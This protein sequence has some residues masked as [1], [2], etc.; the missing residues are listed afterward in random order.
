MADLIYYPKNFTTARRR[1]REL[2][3]Q[4]SR[5]KKIETWQVPSAQAHDL[6]ADSAYFPAQKKAK[7][8]FVFISGV[9]GLEGYTGHAIQAMFLKELLPYADQDETGFLFVHALNPWGF[10]FHS[11]NTENGVNLNRN[12][13]TRPQLYSAQ[14][15]RSLELSDR[16]IPR[17]PVDTEQCHLLQN[18]HETDAGIF[19]ADVSMDDFIK[20]VG[21]GQ[22]HSKEGLE[23]GG[24]GPEPQIRQFIRCLEEIIPQYQDIILFDI[25]TGLGHRGQLHLLTG[26]VEG[27][28]HPH[29]FNEIFNPQQDRDLY[30]FTPADAEGFYETLGATNNI[31]PEIAEPHQRVCA[32]TMEFGTLGHD[33][34]TLLDGLNRWLLEHQGSIYGYA[35]SDLEKK[36]KEKYLEKFFPQ[37]P[38]WQKSVLST[39]RNFLTRVLKRAKSHLANLG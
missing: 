37:D 14:N 27:C 22:F 24:K 34:P 29:L 17:G 28:V 26:D 15:I 1:F 8:L 32:M 20:S 13:S 2:V 16:F 11:R 21:R 35:H 3:Q 36:V 5:N 18:K 6:S 4:A 19:F 25:H 9:H 39:S 30:E 12:C 31:F 7:T 33:M 10:E 23:Y 38:L